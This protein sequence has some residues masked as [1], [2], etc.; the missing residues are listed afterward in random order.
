M[1][2][3]TAVG[4]V[5]SNDIQWIFN[6]T[7][8]IRGE[9][10]TLWWVCPLFPA[11]KRHCLFGEFICHY[12]IKNVCIFLMLHD[13]TATITDF[14]PSGA[15]PPRRTMS[16]CQ[17]LTTLITKTETETAWLC[18]KVCHETFLQILVIPAK[19]YWLVI[20]WLFFQRQQ[21]VNTFIHLE[22]YIS[23]LLDGWARRLVQ[24]FLFFVN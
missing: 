13:H 18:V 12:W 17:S 7:N 8:V 23:C 1:G 22:K 14:S 16:F 20:P 21:Q 3:R 2:K 11:S 5:N 19:L 9:N 24:T 15:V 6:A 10:L 4:L